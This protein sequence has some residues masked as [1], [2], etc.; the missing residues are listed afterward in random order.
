MQVH[1]VSV[2]NNHFRERLTSTV[3]QN[4]VYQLYSL[5]KQA[6]HNGVHPHQMNVTTKNVPV[7]RASNSSW[8]SEVVVTSI[9]LKLVTVQR[10]IQQYPQQTQ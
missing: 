4:I 6:M 9:L 2:A 1:P 5:H 3:T 8:I 7:G 10:S